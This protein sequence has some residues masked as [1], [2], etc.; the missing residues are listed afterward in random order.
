[1]EIAMKADTL[2]A[3]HMGKENTLGKLEL[4]FM[5]ANFLKAFDKE[6]EY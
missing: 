2:M 6:K 3:S 1:M 4:L 5:K